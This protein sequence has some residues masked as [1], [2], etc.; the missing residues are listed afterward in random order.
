[1]V[2]AKLVKVGGAPTPC[3]VSFSVLEGADPSTMFS[4]SF[5]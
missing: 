3:A 1:M 5:F 2:G 4:P